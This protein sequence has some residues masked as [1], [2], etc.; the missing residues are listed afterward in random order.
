MNRGL[1][2]AKIFEIQ[3]YIQ[4]NIL[5]YKLENIETIG[6]NPSPINRINNLYRFDINMKYGKEN[7]DLIVMIIKDI[8]INNKYNIDLTGYRLSITLN[9]VSFY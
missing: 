5:K 1:T 7:K 2:R 6:P 9:P 4:N 3:R 8:L